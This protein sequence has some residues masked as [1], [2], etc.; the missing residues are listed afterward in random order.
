MPSVRMAGI[1]RGTL[2]KV[3]GAAGLNTLVSNHC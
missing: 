1:V 3:N 2:P